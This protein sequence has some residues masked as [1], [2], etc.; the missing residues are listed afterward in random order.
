[1]Q[2]GSGLYQPELPRESSFLQ[3]LLR[4]EVR[5]QGRRVWR[6]FRWLKHGRWRSSRKK[7]EKHPSIKEFVVLSTIGSSQET[8][9]IISI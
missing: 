1:M 9:K 6:W 2:Q 5:T 8:I 7:L 3:N 4:K